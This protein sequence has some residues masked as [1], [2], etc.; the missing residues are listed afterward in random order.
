M[1]S[2]L[3]QRL[4]DRRCNH[5]N[6]FIDYTPGF[7]YKFKQVGFNFYSKAD[8]DI[9]YGPNGEV[10]IVETYV[11]GLGGLREISKIT[12]TEDEIVKL[13]KGYDLY[14][15]SGYKKPEIPQNS[16]DSTQKATKQD[17]QETPIDNFI[18]KISSIMFKFSEKSS[19]IQF[20]E[21]IQALELIKTD[22]QLDKLKEK[23]SYFIGRFL[24][25][26][27]EKDQNAIIEPSETEIKLY[28]VEKLGL[29]SDDIIIEES[30]DERFVKVHLQSKAISRF[31]DNEEKGELV[32][33][34]VG[35]TKGSEEYTLLWDAAL[36][37]I[38]KQSQP[39]EE[40]FVIT[41]AKLYDQFVD[42]SLAT[43]EIILL[44]RTMPNY[45]ANGKFS[46]DMRFILSH[47]AMHMHK[48]SR[49]KI[50]LDD[51]RIL[52]GPPLPTVIRYL[53]TCP[54]I[55]KAGDQYQF[56]RGLNLMEYFFTTKMI[57]DL[58]AEPVEVPASSPPNNPIQE[59]LQSPKIEAIP[60]D[61]TTT[62]TPSSQT[63]T[64]PT[65]LPVDTTPKEQP[66]DTRSSTN[67][68]S[69]RNPFNSGKSLEYWQN[70]YDSKKDSFQAACALL[71]EYSATQHQPNSKPSIVGGNNWSLFVSGRWKTHHAKAVCS[72]L[73]EVFEKRVEEHNLV[74]LLSQIKTKIGTKTVLNPNG[75]LSRILTVIKNNTGIDF[76]NIPETSEPKNTL[77]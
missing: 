31:I 37:L 58:L 42:D 46:T 62:N 56:K 51:L 22:Y 53:E 29:N 5:F 57:D 14:V 74:N 71:F 25:K 63:S 24:L 49:T 50:H 40:P 18:N 20:K 13:S 38:Y 39:Y 70:K 41:K 12:L 3:I 69:L 30:R 7:R 28:L 47:I 11:S 77:K 65:I 43:Q 44:P 52:F 16:E 36:N 8:Y 27:I 45:K 76:N 73:N 61:T 60:L 33:T 32:L 68:F 48:D 75:D 55:E 23:N 15:A 59:Q 54:L 2:A 35:I 21:Q 64:F 26:T 17:L 67:K 10:I 9:E 6:N 66:K 72:A 4:K 1:T 19:P 34:Q